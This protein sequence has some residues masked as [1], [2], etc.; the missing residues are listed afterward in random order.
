MT[1]REMKKLLD[2]VFISELDCEVLVE[3]SGEGVNSIRAMKIEP[4]CS[5]PKVLRIYADQ[6]D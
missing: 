4:T 5:G 3:A 1:V 2:A 6:E